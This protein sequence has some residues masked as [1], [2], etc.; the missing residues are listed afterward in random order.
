MVNVNFTIKDL[1]LFAGLD[2]VY[3]QMRVIQSNHDQLRTR[4][5]GSGE[6]CKIGLQL[7]IIECAN[8]A[9]HLKREFY[10]RMERYGIEEGE[11]WYQSIIDALVAKM[12]D[13]KWTPDGESSD[14]CIFYNNGCTIYEYRPLVCRAYGTIVTVD[15]F[16][17]RERLQDGTVDIFAGDGIK[18]I[19]K[20]FDSLVRRFNLNHK[21]DAFVVYMPLGVLKFLLP[22]EALVK[23]AAET[24]PKFWSGHPIYKTYFTERY[25][26]ARGEKKKSE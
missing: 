25:L 13:E 24:D 18:K 8:I 9:F 2:L 16:C 6:C 23:L 7:P 19:V 20:E 15:K 3:N 26:D 22:K 14:H 21:K 12:Y 10:L 5:K 11:K 1:S 17:P 4:C